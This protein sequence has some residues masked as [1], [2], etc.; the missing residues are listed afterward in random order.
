MSQYGTDESDESEDFDADDPL[1]NEKSKDKT[2]EN[3]KKEGKPKGKQNKGKKYN[4]K[5]IQNNPIY[6][7]QIH[8]NYNFHQGYYNYNDPF[9]KYPPIPNK[10]IEEEVKTAVAKSRHIKTD[11]KPMSYLYLPSHDKILLVNYLFNYKNNRDRY[12]QFGI[13]YKGGLFLTGEPGCGKSST[14]IAM[15]TYL[16]KDIYYMDLGRIKTNHELKLCIDYI[17]TNSQKGGIIIFEDVDCMTD[18]V[19][20]R[21]YLNINEISNNV[22]LENTSI[23]KNMSNEND[24]L[25]LSFFLNILDGTMAPEDVIF[26]IT[27]NHPEVLDHALIRPGRMDISINIKKCCREQLEQIYYDLF[28]IKLDESIAC[29]FKEH[30]FMTA[31][32]ILYLFHNTYKNVDPQVLLEKFLD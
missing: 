26:V 31:E 13:S 11:K 2:E 16:G 4:I 17:S 9:L 29:R 32:V 22:P 14:I 23:T 3:K 18:I 20:R 28:G 21:N 10:F 1:S 8:G 5:E 30:Y 24:A 27:S 25:S 12:E 19:K 15:A 7:G 6:N